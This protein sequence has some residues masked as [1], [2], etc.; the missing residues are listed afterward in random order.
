MLE[1]ELWPEERIAVMQRQQRVA[2]TKH[3]TVI[4]EGQDTHV[5][6][7]ESHSIESM[8]GRGAPPSQL[9][10]A[11]LQKAPFNPSIF[12]GVWTRHPHG[13]FLSMRCIPMPWPSIK[14][15][16]TFAGRQ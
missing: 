6:K 1:E 2:R 3:L 13:P 10:P 7:E 4:A 5:L 12:T 11:S 15:T 8:R 16:K 14:A 9:Q